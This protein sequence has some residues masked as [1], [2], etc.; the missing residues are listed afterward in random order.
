MGDKVSKYT[1]KVVIKLSKYT[2]IIEVNL[3]IYLLKQT[4]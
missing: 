1:R 2:Y 4:C 3:N